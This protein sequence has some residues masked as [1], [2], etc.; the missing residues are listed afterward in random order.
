MEHTFVEVRFINGH[1]RKNYFF[2]NGHEGIELRD[3]IVVDTTY[4][5][6]IAEVVGIPETVD[7]N[8]GKWVMDKLDLTRF[9]EIK[10]IRDKE[11]EVKRRKQELR[12]EMKAYFEATVM[13]DMMAKFAEED[14]EMRKLKAEYDSLTEKESN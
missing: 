6:Q 12:K 4:G 2:K 9:N 11:K 7:R 3:L 13:E 10:A 8:V 14:E 5:P 1:N